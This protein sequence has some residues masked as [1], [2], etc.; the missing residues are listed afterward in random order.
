MKYLYASTYYET[1]LDKIK[2]GK[3]GKGRKKKKE[4]THI[5][6]EWNSYKRWNESY[7]FMLIIIIFFLLWSFQ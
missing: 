2:G 3:E 5:R 6:I 7:C 4:R 1:S